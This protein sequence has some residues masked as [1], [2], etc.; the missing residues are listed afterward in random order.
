[1]LMRRV[2]T[3]L[4]LALELV[5]FHGPLTREPAR[6]KSSRNLIWSLW[7]PLNRII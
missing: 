5:G 1:M 2:F 4:Y 7:C 3:L 6:K